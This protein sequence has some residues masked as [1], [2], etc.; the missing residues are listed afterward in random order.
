MMA[1]FKSLIINAETRKAAQAIDPNLVAKRPE[2]A[3]KQLREILTKKAQDEV[4]T[5]LSDLGIDEKAST[6]YP[7]FSRHL[8]G[9]QS[10]MPNDGIL[11]RFI[12]AKL[13]K[14][15]GK[16]TERDTNALSRSIEHV[17]VIM[18]ELRGMLK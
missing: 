1:Q 17:E 5:L 14:K 13:V 10:T 9:I 15:F 7:K 2:I 11:V 18:A 8:V 16:V 12:N 3:R 4:A 6:L